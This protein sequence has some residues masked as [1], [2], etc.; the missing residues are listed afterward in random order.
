MQLKLLCPLQRYRVMSEQL[1]SAC[2][3][4]E[5]Y[6]N[7]LEA[8]A[9]TQTG[10][11]LC[12]RSHWGRLRISGQDRLTFLHNQSTNSFK[13][14]RPGQGCETVFITSTARTIDLVT[15][16]VGQDEVLLLTS[17]QRR[18]QLLQW[19]DRYIF[20]GDQVEVS[21][22]TE[23]TAT[24]TLVGPQSST[25]LTQLGVTQLPEQPHHHVTSAIGDTEIQIATGS[26]LTL[27]GYTL[28]LSKAQVQP[29]WEQFLQAGALPAGT[30]VWEQLRMQ[31]GR[32]QPDHELTED[33]NPLEAGLWHTISLDKGC[34]IG[35]ET[36]ARLQTYQ[37]VKQ[38][39]WGIRLTTPVPT[40]T[41]ITLEDSKV[42]RLTSIT[43]LPDQVLGLGYIKT[44]VGMP[45]QQV[46]IG[47][48]QGE[49][50]EL[51]YLTYP[52]ASS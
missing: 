41:P 19:L 26:G 35:Q 48:Q 46:Q 29:L 3:M 2:Q 42:G 43:E 22:Q 18:Q 15:A 13:M 4:I 25:L 31:Q 5:S 52:P 8:L 50:I 11:V 45:G 51:P 1:T 20:F 39:L 24:L 9:A 21:D 49:L 28:I 6:D 7:D 27:P 38:H 36:I 32:P 12:D 37:G 47:D 17:P 16:Y 40:D 23:A 30:R 33:Y 44:K 10:V 34:Y 14:L